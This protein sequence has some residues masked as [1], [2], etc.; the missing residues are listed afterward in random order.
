[1][2]RGGE[3][4]LVTKAGQDCRA[5]KSWGSGHMSDPRREWKRMKRKCSKTWVASILTTRL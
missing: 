2:K 5:M 1:M 4:G 3:R